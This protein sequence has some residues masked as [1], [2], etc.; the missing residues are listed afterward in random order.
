[1]SNIDIQ[2]LHDQFQSILEL[3]I[4]H[5]K[6][7]KKSIISSQEISIAY[8]FFN[9]FNL[10]RE[11]LMKLQPSLGFTVNI[12]KFPKSHYTRISESELIGLLNSLIISVQKL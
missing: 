11:D 12:E 2:A 9:S 7:M 3:S 8:N 5:L 1:M 10:A 4:Y 6:V